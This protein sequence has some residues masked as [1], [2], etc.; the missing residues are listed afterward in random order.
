MKPMYI[1]VAL[2]IA[3]IAGIFF[4]RNYSQDNRVEATTAYDSFAQCLADAGATFYGAYWCP[5]CQAQKALFENSSKLP[6][7]ECSTPGGQ[8]QTQICIEKKIEGY[9]TW[10]F[11]DGSRLG[12]EQTLEALAEKTSCELPTS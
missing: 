5:H 11:A 12:G 6:Y 8:G 4:L 1:Y 7:V 10:E 2:V 9:P 3:L